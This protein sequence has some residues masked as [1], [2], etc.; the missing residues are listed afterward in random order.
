MDKKRL[1]SKISRYD[2]KPLTLMEVCGSHTAAVFRTGI[3]NILPPSVRLISGPGCPVCVADDAFISRAAAL[4]G[5]ARLISFGDMARTVG[6]LRPGTRV[7][8]AASPT[9]AV[10]RAKAAPEEDVV[11]LSVGFETTN[12]VC[13][14]SVL[15]AREEN[16]KNFFLLTCNKTMPPIMEYLAKA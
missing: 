7:E 2:G 11:F 12:P 5:R 8:T 14:L 10:M 6:R 15:R 13:A 3:R 9:D 4:E 1:L 16:V